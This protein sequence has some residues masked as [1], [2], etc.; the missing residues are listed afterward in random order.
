[1]YTEKIEMLID[2][3]WCQGSEGKTQSLINPAT[4]KC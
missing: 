4:E 1:M 2:G 3:R